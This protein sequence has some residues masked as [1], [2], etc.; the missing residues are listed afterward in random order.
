[1]GKRQTKKD[2]RYVY[3]LGALIAKEERVLLKGQSRL[4]T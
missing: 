1:M 2:R 3:E 4:K